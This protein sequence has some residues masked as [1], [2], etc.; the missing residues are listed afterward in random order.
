MVLRMRIKSFDCVTRIAGAV[1]R[2]RREEGGV[3]D[4][5]GAV[6]TLRSLRL[7]LATELRFDSL[8]KRLATFL[9]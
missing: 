9:L 7:R 5:R 1:E 2:G 3:F 4:G 6:N 8:S